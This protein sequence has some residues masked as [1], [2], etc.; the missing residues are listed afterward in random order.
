MMESSE[1]IIVS[2]YHWPASNFCNFFPS[3]PCVIDNLLSEIF[4]NDNGDESP[5][6]V[7]C[8]QARSMVNGKINEQGK[9]YLWAQRLAGLDF[10]GVV[11]CTPQTFI[12]T[13]FVETVG[14]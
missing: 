7:N 4:P 11:R 2:H 6:W 14:F 5:S 3:Q 9:P 1:N 12:N 10:N 13:E 8:F